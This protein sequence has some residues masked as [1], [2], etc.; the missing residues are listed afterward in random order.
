MLKRGQT[1]IKFGDDEIQI[2][3]KERVICDCLRYQEK[4][5]REDF[6]RAVLA[7]IQDEDK[8][9]ASLLEL[10]RERKVLKKV[11]TMIGIWL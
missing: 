2:Y 8:D 4:M 6:K 1:R 10:A 7:Y 11:Q 3:T 5:N 9:I